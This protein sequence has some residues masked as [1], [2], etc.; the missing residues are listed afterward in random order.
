MPVGTADGAAIVSAEFFYRPLD[1]PGM[2]VDVEIA[3]DQLCQ[4]PRAN[5]LARDQLLLQEGQHILAD[6]VGAAGSRL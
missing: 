1:R 6:L 3:A 5:R 2:N 4:C